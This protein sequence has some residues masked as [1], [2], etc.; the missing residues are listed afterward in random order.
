MYKFINAWINYLRLTKRI[1]AFPV[2]RISFS[3]LYV[4]KYKFVT[5]CWQI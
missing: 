5:Y 3:L 1:I 4:D 2:L